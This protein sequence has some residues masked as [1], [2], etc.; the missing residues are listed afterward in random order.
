MGGARACELRVAVRCDARVEAGR[1]GFAAGQVAL[2]LHVQWNCGFFDPNT[3]SAIPRPKRGRQTTGMR[4]PDISI[5]EIRGVTQDTATKVRYKGQRYTANPCLGVRSQR[6]I[7]NRAE[8]GTQNSR[9][10]NVGSH[11]SNAGTT[12]ITSRRGGVIR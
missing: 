9:E 4:D 8:V 10:M 2:G 11:V 5:S 6:T 3:G 12:A 1:R 7:Q